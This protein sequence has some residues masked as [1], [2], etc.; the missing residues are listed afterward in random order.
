MQLEVSG[1]VLR[2][3]M[4]MSK[5]KIKKMKISISDEEL[6]SVFDEF[7]YTPCEDAAIVLNVAI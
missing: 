7:H 6:G 5:P 1:A 2:L 4:Y 3:E